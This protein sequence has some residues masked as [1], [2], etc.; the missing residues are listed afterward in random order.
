VTSRGAPAAAYVYRAVD[1]SVLLPYLTAYYLPLFYRW[2]P[3]F[4]TANQITLA[5]SGFMWLMVGLLVSGVARSSWAV[6]A[7]FCVLLHAYVVG[8]YLDGM[9]ARRTGTSSPLGEFLDHYL[10]IW[11]G[12]ITV[13]VAFALVGI[14]PGWACYATMWAV[15]IGFGA[16]VMERQERGELHFGPIGTLEAFAL[17]LVFALSW[18]FPSVEAFWRRPGFGGVANYWILVILTIGAFLGAAVQAIRRVGRCPREFALFGVLSALLAAALV[19]HGVS[20]GRGGLILALFGADFIGRMMGTYLCHR[21]AP[22]A[23]RGILLWIAPLT[24]DRVWP[25][26]PE[27]TR[28]TLL[29]LLGLYVLLR[30]TWSLAAILSD[31]RHHWRWVNAR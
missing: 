19:A 17:V 7:S 11:N 1:R 31:L 10:D 22:K 25:V 28:D 2:V 23:D 4:T 14:A 8:D 9:H 26:L 16:T 21:P 24:L 20:R 13:F 12:Q 15:L 5:A 3:G 29:V 30:A 18:M 27:G 6:A